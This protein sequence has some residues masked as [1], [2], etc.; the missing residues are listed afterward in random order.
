MSPYTPMEY[1]NHYMMT[2]WKSGHYTH[3]GL[4]NIH[5]KEPRIPRKCG[6]ISIFMI[7]RR[8][9]PKA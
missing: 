6:Y 9:F 8:K 5:S 4:D 1:G 3:C 7:Q 2:R